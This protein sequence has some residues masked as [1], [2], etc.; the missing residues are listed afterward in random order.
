MKDLCKATISMGQAS[1]AM[2]RANH[3]AAS[4]L[5]ATLETDKGK[6]FQ[7]S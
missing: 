1:R 7:S 6:A 2:A 5:S 4:N 3:T